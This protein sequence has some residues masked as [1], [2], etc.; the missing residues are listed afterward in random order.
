YLLHDN[1]GSM[2]NPADGLVWD[3]SQPIRALEGQNLNGITYG[4]WFT[5]DVP[6]GG[7]KTITWYQLQDYR[8]QYKA[9][10]NIVK[11]VNQ[12]LATTQAS[13][14]AAAAAEATS[15]KRVFAAADQGTGSKAIKPTITGPLVTRTPAASSL[16]ATRAP[17]KYRQIAASWV[18]WLKAQHL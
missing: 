4:I 12:I 11:W 18:A 2:I 13:A 6:A 8:G 3:S 10:E 17:K 7:D 9:D 15:S 1:S 5:A 16:A 14:T